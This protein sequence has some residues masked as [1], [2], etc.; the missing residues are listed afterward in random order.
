MNLSR[1]HIMEVLDADANLKSITPI[2]QELYINE[3]VPGE[4]VTSILD[5][6][7]GYKIS[8]GN[9][10]KLFVKNK[11]D[12]SGVKK[13]KRTKDS[14]ARKRQAILHMMKFNSSVRYRPLLQSQ[15][16]P[17]Q[18]RLQERAVYSIRQ[19]LD[20]MFVRGSH[21][22]WKSSPIGFVRPDGTELSPNRWQ[23]IEAYCDSMSTM[24]RCNQTKAAQNIL[25]GLSNYL[26]GFIN[27][28]DPLFLGRIWKLA[29]LLHSL[30]RRAPQLQAVSTIFGSMRVDLHIEGEHE[31]PLSAILDCIID[32]EEADFRSTMQ[33]GFRETLKTLDHKLTEEN[34]MVLKLWST[35]AQYFCKQYTKSAKRK[36]LFSV[37]SSPTKSSIKA[38]RQHASLSMPYE[39]LR[40]NI[41]SDIMLLKFNQV[42]QQC[43]NPEKMSPRL[44]RQS[45]I[46]V[47][48]SHYY[49][50]ATFWVCGQ[51]DLAQNMARNI[52]ADTQPALTS[53]PVWNS[54][55]MAF[56]AASKIIATAQHQE[57]E[58]GPCERTLMEAIGLLRTG[59]SICRIRAVGLCLTLS[60]WK[61]NWETT[62][63]RW[64]SMH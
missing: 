35:Y 39:R 23:A 15:P 28:I 34:M 50:Y 33:L 27:Q 16:F 19:S 41:R 62:K 42:W 29:L 55:T 24:L 9:L 51:T 47:C 4:I 17:Q 63:H 10:R 26:A 44:W 43:Y 52:V 3:N 59:D 25:D 46:C 40:E 1:S 45:D 31:S 11:G 32:V 18:Y 64:I 12:A 61:R 60:S 54:K 14:Q 5:E 38:A 58:F 8:D 30:D 2:I 53:H 22:T 20:S 37:P 57:A 56:T 6:F 7:F 36:P 21:G 48:I 49:A 13:R